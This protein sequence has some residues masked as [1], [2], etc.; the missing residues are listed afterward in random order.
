MV[1][2][3][4]W[5]VISTDKEIET[6]RRRRLGKKVG[7]V[8]QVSRMMGKNQGERFGCVITSKKVQKFTVRNGS[9]EL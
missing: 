8:F 2:V 5:R 6:I 1:N 4:F 9:S 3:K 7:S